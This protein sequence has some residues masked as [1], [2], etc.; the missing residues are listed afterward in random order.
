MRR[1][2]VREVWVTYTSYAQAREDVLLLR[3]LKTVPRQDGFYIDVGANDPTIDSVTKLF[4]DDG[5]RGINIEPSPDWFGRLERCRPRDINLQVAASNQSG[6]ITFHDIVGEQLGTVVEVFADR[7]SED[8]RT[9]RSY[10]V[11][12]MTLAEICALHAPADI[13][14]LKIDVEG[15][16]GQ[17]LQGMDFERFRPW[18]LVI[19]AIEPNKRDVPTYSE[20]DDMVREAGY[21]FV[22][23]D[24]LN[25]YYVA[26]EHAELARYFAIPAD[27]YELA[28][29]QRERR[30]L[31][32]ALQDAKQTIALLEQR[33]DPERD[34]HS[35]MPSLLRRSLL[36][37]AE[38]PSS[39]QKYADAAELLF[40]GGFADAAR[41]F[42]DVL[43][44]RRGF[45]AWALAQQLRVASSTGLWKHANWSGAST[46]PEEAEAWSL[47]EA[48]GQLR[49]LMALHGQLASASMLEPRRGRRSATDASPDSPADL[50]R[51]CDQLCQLLREPL[52]ASARE[53][54]KLVLAELH[55]TVLDQPN[56]DAKRHVGEDL[57]H[58]AKGAAANSLRQ[59]FGLIYEIAYPPYG[60]PALLHAAARLENGGLGA[61]FDNTRRIAA[62]SHDLF[63]LVQIA[64]GTDASG[65]ID[66]NTLERWLV[67]LSIHMP[68]QPLHEFADALGDLGLMRPLSGLLA[69]VTRRSELQSDPALIWCIRDSGL[70]NGDLPLALE[71]QSLVVRLRSGEGT[72]WIVLGEIEAT[73]GN[74]G[75]AEAAF[76]QGLALEPDHAIGRE[77]LEALREGWFKRFEVKSGFG[78]PP[79]RK[80]LRNRRRRSELAAMLPGFSLPQS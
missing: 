75:R 50:M 55:D 66:R 15:H 10:T 74:V 44:I 37:C 29:L 73:A 38:E 41:L 45:S 16:E 13:H 12:T 14:F 19:E 43:F 64:A 54:L 5:W 2:N 61:Y 20:W 80:L 76:L 27:D 49:D 34:Q 18:I 58:I 30:A 78:T 35:S 77:R 68:Q 51:L 67:L 21:R 1:V 71:A 31:Q 39:E 72:E 59:F 17:V 69:R 65:S 42:H 53:E 24:I 48:A 52:S 4:Y 32:L 7:H 63:G 57:D 26:E 40:T 23:T 60:S 3:A 33:L 11:R 70:D 22:H 62:T 9:R 47:E 8:G 25:R 79:E 36:S 6:D 28:G 46:L 56:M